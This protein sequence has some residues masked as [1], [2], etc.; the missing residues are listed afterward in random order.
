MDLE[1]LRLAASQVGTR[2]L[3]QPSNGA[4]KIL[5]EAVFSGRE[6]PNREAEL[7]LCQL[8]LAT[9]A[10]A[11]DWKLNKRQ[12]WESLKATVLDRLVEPCLTSP[13]ERAEWAEVERCLVSIAFG[14]EKPV[15]AP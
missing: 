15:S 9:A 7:V 10:I 2:A 8:A 1:R 14:P 6:G 13:A 4:I 11:T 12:C 5:H 3:S